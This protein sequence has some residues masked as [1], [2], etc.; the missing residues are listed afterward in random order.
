MLPSEILQRNR[1]AVMDA[2]TELLKGQ[3]LPG[4]YG[5]G[6]VTFDVKDGR[7]Q[8]SVRVMGE[9]SVRVKTT[10]NSCDVSPSV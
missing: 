3:S 9:R 6:T 10:E 8:G 1:D 5:V 2:V 7:V 4:Y